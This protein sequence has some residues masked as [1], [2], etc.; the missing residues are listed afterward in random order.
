MG[1]T[2]L[3]ALINNMEILHNI[4]WQLHEAPSLCLCVCASVWLSEKA[5]I[6]WLAIYECVF[7]QLNATKPTT[8]G[9]NGRHQP[10]PKLPNRSLLISK[11]VAQRPP[12][13]N[14][15]RGG[16]QQA[17]RSGNDN[18]GDLCSSGHL[19]IQARSVAID[20]AW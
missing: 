5:L 7:P 17:A 3:Q 18:V 8:A 16:R 10:Q 1:S 20:A 13:S 15:G 4:V 12:M 9:L 19:S 11:R 2:P 6:V 14:G